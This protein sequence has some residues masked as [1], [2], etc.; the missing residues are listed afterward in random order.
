ML[1]HEYGHHIQQITGI[2][3]QYPNN[4]TGEDSNGVR[5]ELQADCF[6]GAW[7]AGASQTVDENGVPYLKP[8]TQQE[9][10]DAL[11]AA[12]TVGDDHIQQ[13]SGGAVNPETWTHGS[14]EQRAR[15]FS[16]GLDGGIAACDT[17][18]VAGSDL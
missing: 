8:P 1:A 4:G 7:V 3:Q 10:N 12:Q 6:A 13:Q 2:M 5:T 18:A 16:T 17:F 9:I 14:S 15:W 11:N